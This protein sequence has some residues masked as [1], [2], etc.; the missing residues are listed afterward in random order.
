MDMN[1]YV[2]KEIKPLKNPYNIVDDLFSVLANIESQTISQTDT[3]SIEKNWTVKFSDIKCIVETRS[4]Y[5]RDNLASAYINATHNIYFKYREDI[6]IND[7]IIIEGNTYDINAIE[8]NTV[9]DIITIVAQKII[10]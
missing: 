1:N 9:K 3:G 5:N 2:G 6:D 10:Q 4:H 8:F 7:R